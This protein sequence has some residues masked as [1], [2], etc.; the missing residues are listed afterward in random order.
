MLLPG[1]VVQRATTLVAAIMDKR[2]GSILL[3][4]LH[5]T[6]L[7]CSEALV[8]AASMQFAVFN[9]WNSI[10]VTNVLCACH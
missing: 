9:V 10:V 3:K 5:S 4:Q 7:R 2:V 8:D 6:Q 1:S